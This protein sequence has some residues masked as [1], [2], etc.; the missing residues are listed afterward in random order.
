MPLIPAEDKTNSATV[1]AVIPTL[2]PAPRRRIE[3]ELAKIATSGGT[4]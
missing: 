1:T 2:F 3:L 4:S